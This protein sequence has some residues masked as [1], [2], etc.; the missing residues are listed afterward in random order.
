MKYLDK[1]RNFLDR[2]GIFVGQRVKFRDNS[3]NLKLESD[4]F[5][6]GYSPSLKPDN[7][8]TVLAIDCVL[9]APPLAILSDAENAK[10]K[11]DCI[12]SGRNGIFFTCK[13]CISPL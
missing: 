6:Q 12:V 13:D 2:D 11:N 7:E 1:T 9:P 10:R 4:G 8:Y 5:L 3:Y